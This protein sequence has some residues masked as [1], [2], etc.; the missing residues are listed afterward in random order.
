MSSGIGWDI[1]MR[2][3]GLCLLA[4]AAASLGGCGASLPS[5]T[6][7]TL[8]GGGAKADAK[9]AIKN[10][11]VS[12]AMDVAATSARAIKCGYN[13]DPAKLKNQYLAAETASDPAE[14]P[15][16]NQVYDVTFSGVSKALATK[17]NE[18]CSKEKTARIKTALNRHLAGDYTP[19]P[20]ENAPEEASLFGGGGGNTSSETPFNTKAP[21]EN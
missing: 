1:R 18:Y 14:A 15:K 20:P 11:P 8:F 17:G 3:A 21:F 13:F 6:T 10:D 9:P 4:L 2:I 7:G 16:L 5:L 12:R 19:S